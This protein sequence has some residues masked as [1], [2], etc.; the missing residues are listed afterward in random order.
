MVEYWCVAIKETIKRDGIEKDG[1][2][3]NKP[4]WL[5]EGRKTKIKGRRKSSREEKRRVEKRKEEEEQ[6]R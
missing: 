5:N 2:E 1:V 4:H 6:W 3:E